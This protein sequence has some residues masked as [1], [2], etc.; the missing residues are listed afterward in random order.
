[1]S[2]EQARGLAIAPA[3]DIYALGCVMFE[4]LT[5]THVFDGD[6]DVQVIV[7]HVET[8]PPHLTALR[9]DVPAAVDELV[10]WMLRKDPSD[11]PASAEL[12][13]RACQSLRQKLES[14]Q[15]LPDPRRSAP[16]A[17][18]TS[19][20][21]PHPRRS[22]PH[23]AQVQELIDTGR[24]LTTPA[25]LTPRPATQEVDLNAELARELSDEAPVPADELEPERRRGRIGLFSFLALVLLAGGGAFTHWRG[26]WNFEALIPVKAPEPAPQPAPPAPVPAPAPPTTATTAAPGPA[27]AAA[28]AP[29]KKRKRVVQAAKPG[30]LTREALFQRIFFLEKRV[31]QMG[32]SASPLLAGLSSARSAARQAQSDEERQEVSRA[33]DEIEEQLDPQ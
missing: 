4:M 21:T 13:G 18:T 31:G 16:R 24:S 12:L 27:P 30:T 10:W 3:A 1:M 14:G 33:L 25:P 19:P 6:S 8:E 22:G 29:A 9:P 23:P 15:E 20:P 28:P 26:L 7:K 2:P 11:R 17:T 32:D 5:G